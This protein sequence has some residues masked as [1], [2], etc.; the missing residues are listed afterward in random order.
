[1]IERPTDHPE[2]LRQFGI[3]GLVGPQE[4]DQRARRVP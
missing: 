2:L 1:M 4:E 3:S